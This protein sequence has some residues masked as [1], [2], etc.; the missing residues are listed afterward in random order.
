MEKVS[1]VYKVPLY[2]VNYAPTLGDRARLEF[3]E[4]IIVIKGLI[5]TAEE[6]ITGY[7]DF[8]ILG[9]DFI[10][11]CTHGDGQKLNA[12]GI[13]VTGLSRSS[14]LVILENDFNNDNLAITDDVNSYYSSKD[15]NKWVRLYNEKYNNKNSSVDNVFRKRK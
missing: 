7:K 3:V 8:T 10:E 15:Q 11:K 9:N 12:P 4:D 6:V 14:H 5:R 2:Q 13:S 1:R